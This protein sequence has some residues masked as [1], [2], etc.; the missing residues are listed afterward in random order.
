MF[1]RALE[2]LY[3]RLSGPRACR[4]RR[5]PDLFDGHAYR[6]IDEFYAA[7]QP[8]FDRPRE[9][10]R[11]P[12]E[13]DSLEL[14][15]TNERPSSAGYTPCAFDSPLVSDWPANNVVPFKWF[16]ETATRSKTMVLFVPGWGRSNQSF[17]IEMCARLLGH[18]VDAGLLTVP[19]H[20]ARAP[21]GTRSGEFF[22]SANLFWTVANF[23]QL[24]VEIRSLIR[25]MRERYEHV[26]LLG[27]SSG[28]FQAGLA[29]DCEAVDVLF[30]LVG[31]CDVA[32]ITWHGAATQW[33]RR[34]LEGRGVTQDELGR[35]WSIADQAI[36]GRHCRARFR[37]HYI[38]RY[39]GIV[40]TEYQLRLWEAYGRPDRLDL[41]VSHVSLFFSLPRIVD[42]MAAFMRRCW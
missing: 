4:E 5:V 30:T 23:R 38:A 6:S 2:K 14:R 16:R 26:G 10:Y 7:C 34:D 22:I 25:F 35:A 37:K 24:T 27:M 9:F 20:Q 17:E 18:G 36:L 41:Q 33:I 19:F 15:P 40:P 12:L 11:A 13:Q 28:A 42:D 3:M 21:A 32:G 8:Y 39:D 29:S 31:G 1:A